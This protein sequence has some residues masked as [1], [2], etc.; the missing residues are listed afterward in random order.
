MQGEGNIEHDGQTDLI[1]KVIVQRL[2]LNSNISLIKTKEIKHYVSCQSLMYS[3]AK[4]V[5]FGIC[6]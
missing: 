5:N 4:Q 1:Y 3:K 2:Y 6:D